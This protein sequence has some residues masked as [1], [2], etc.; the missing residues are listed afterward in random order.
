MNK[1][2]LKETALNKEQLFERTDKT[3][4]EEFKDQLIHLIKSETLK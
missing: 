4:R 2:R 1:L 3:S